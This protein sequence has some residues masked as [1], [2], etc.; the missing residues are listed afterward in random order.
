MSATVLA[1]MIGQIF[2]CV[3][4][5]PDNKEMIFEVNPGHSFTFYHM[6]EG[7][8]SVAIVDIKGDLEDMEDTPVTAADVITKTDDSQAGSPTWT[9]LR[10]A[11]NKGYLTVL[12]CGESKGNYSQ[13]VTLKINKELTL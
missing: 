1:E 12:W 5:T 13:S 7:D 4:M 2:S 10:F 8:E 11:S 6:Q 3:D 9:L